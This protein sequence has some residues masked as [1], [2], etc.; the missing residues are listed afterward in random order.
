MRGINLNLLPVLRELLRKRNVT[1]AAAALNMSQ[2]AVSEALGRLRHIFHDE[3]LVQD[4]RVMIPTA[5]ADRLAPILES[6]LG[7]VE[8]IIAPNE[9]D[10]ASAKGTIK[11]ASADYV[12]LLCG[13]RLSARLALQAPGLELEFEARVRGERD[14]RL[15][16]IDFLIAPAGGSRPVLDAFESMPLFE[17]D[18]VC[19][20]ADSAP[21]Q[22]L[23]LERLRNSRHVV[24]TARGIATAYSMTLLKQAGVTPFQAVRVTNFLSVPFMV[25]NTNNIALI[26]R[27]LAER[28]LPVARVRIEE[29]PFFAPIRMIAV[30]NNA[31]KNDPIHSWFR[32][33]LREVAAQIQGPVSPR[34]EAQA[35][36]PLTDEAEF[37][38]NS[39]DVRRM[40]SAP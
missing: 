25:E 3:I 29:L 38:D 14:L 36:V 24:V 7:D 21:R 17:D 32:Q 18:Y 16:Q 19:L 33:V 5:F 26:Q 8:A 39:G 28:L 23:D 15:G 20:V 6:A 11:I 30:W 34:A 12:F 31:K 1:H 4:K 37:G 13:S 22:T 10:P 40:L 2:P 9:F 27:K 35:L